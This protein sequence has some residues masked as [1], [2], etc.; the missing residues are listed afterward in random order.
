M[1]RIRVAL[2]YGGKSGEHE[3]SLISAYS[4]LE[5]L[6]PTH[7]DVVAIG[8]DQQGQWYYNQLPDLMAD[9]TKREHHQ[10]TAKLPTST[11]I[12]ISETEKTKEI[13]GGPIDVVFPMIHGSLGEDGCLQGFLEM[14]NLPY[15]GSGVLASAIGMDK[16]VAKRLAHL[17]GAKTAP[18][19]AYTKAVFETH[20]EKIVND[21][22]EHLGL[23]VFVKPAHLGSSV[24][25]HKATDHDSLYWGIKDAFK[26]DEKIIIE[27]SIEDAQEIEVSVLE[28]PIAGELP[29]VS[30][31]GEIRPGSA[32]DFYSYEAKYLDPNGAELI[33]P[34]E[35]SKEKTEEIQYEARTIFTALTCESMAR[36]DF[37]LERGTGR[38][39]FNEINTI[40]GFTPISMYPKL[41]E[42]SGLPYKELLRILIDLAISR[43]KR[44]QS[45]QVSYTQK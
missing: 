41:W 6:D 8:I 43:H 22:I 7:F 44:K 14:A 24:G 18:Y 13:I 9:M 28:N 23:P 33:I 12:T 10:L 19:K 17:A 30:I 11:A 39:L 27:A 2:V 20:A 34:A 5:A 35:L 16:D 38:V 40:P 15:I 26:Y 42:A 1:S 37:F 4:I 25:I 45:L 3:V 36:V 21:I 31:P 29:L 32:H